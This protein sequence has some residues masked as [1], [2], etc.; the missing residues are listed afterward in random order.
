MKNSSMGKTKRTGKKIRVRSEMNLYSYDRRRIARITFLGLPGVGVQ[1]VHSVHDQEELIQEVEKALPH[2]IRQ[3]SL[4][5]TMF[6]KLG[7]GLESDPILKQGRDI[8]DF[9]KGIQHGN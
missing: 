8:Q 9:L 5:A 7:H 1:K 6:E 2:Y 4:L 3:Y